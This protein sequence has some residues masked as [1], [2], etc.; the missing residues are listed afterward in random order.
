MPYS[1]H[2]C[3]VAAYESIGIVKPKIDD[4]PL[5]C[6]PTT[7]H[8]R[9]MSMIDLKNPMNKHETKKK[10]VITKIKRQL[11]RIKFHTSFV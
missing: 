8:A 2:L 5:D 11:K 4:E 9:T 7:K 3:Y 6:D 10:K 1:T